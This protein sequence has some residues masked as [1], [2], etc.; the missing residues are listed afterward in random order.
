MVIEHVMP[1]ILG[2]R[3]LSANVIKV[4]SQFI[5]LAT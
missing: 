2:C 3:R 1:N 4:T 5:L